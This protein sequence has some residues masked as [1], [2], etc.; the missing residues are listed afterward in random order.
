MLRSPVRAPHLLCRIPRQKAS[1]AG[2]D[3]KHNL[4]LSVPFPVP[5]VMLA[6]RHKSPRDILPL[7]KTHRFLGRRPR[8]SPTSRRAS[9]PKDYL[10]AP[11]FRLSRVLIAR[12]KKSRPANQSIIR[13]IFRS[14]T[15][16]FGR[17][18]VGVHFACAWPPQGP[19]GN[20]E[21]FLAFGKKKSRPQMGCILGV[22]HLQ[23]SAPQALGGPA[24][25]VPLLTLG[26][27]RACQLLS[28]VLKSDSWL[29][30]KGSE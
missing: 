15:S 6:V 14:V 21:A 29:L 27:L 4:G 8:R 26:R 11:P 5:D 2:W 12:Q 7:S 25:G 23:Q 24:W 22:Q 20:S 1:L 16:T 3:H 30:V 28:A 17:P 9:R 10:V 18:G 13:T 19:S